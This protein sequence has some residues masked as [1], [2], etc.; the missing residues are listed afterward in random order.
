MGFFFF[1]PSSTNPPLFRE[2]IIM[3]MNGYELLICMSL[4]TYNIGFW[5]GR[6]H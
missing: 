5:F 3:L 1:S 4:A 6:I 2:M